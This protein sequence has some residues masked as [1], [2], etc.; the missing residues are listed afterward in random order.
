MY[1]QARQY[2]C[3][4]IDTAGTKGIHRSIQDDI[5]LIMHVFQGPPGCLEYYTGTTGVLRNYGMPETGTIT[6]SGI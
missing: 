6:A 2:Q 3:T 1:S 5:E 4:D